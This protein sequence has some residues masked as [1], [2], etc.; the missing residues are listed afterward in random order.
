MLHMAYVVPICIMAVCCSSI[1]IKLWFSRSS[2]QPTQREIDIMHYKKK[3]RC[4]HNPV[5][6]HHFQ[7]HECILESV[8][9]LCDKM[10]GLFV[11]DVLISLTH[12]FHQYIILNYKHGLCQTAP[13]LSYNSNFNNRKINLPCMSLSVSSR[14]SRNNVFVIFKAST[15]S[16]TSKA[17]DM[18]L[19]VCCRNLSCSSV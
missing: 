4:L 19:F 10:A 2:G 13:Y 1:A 6:L 5:T 11:S 9:V 17:T 7:D 15:L 16:S 18:R 8:G 12:T 14:D 3:V